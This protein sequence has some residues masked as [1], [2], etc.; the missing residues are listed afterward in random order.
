MKTYNTAGT[1]TA[2]GVTKVRFANDYVG[3]FKILVKNG[4]ENI[5]LIELGEDLTKAEVCKVLLAHP[6]FQSE[7]KQS[8]IAEFV[9]RNVKD[10]VP[11]TTAEPTIAD[12]IEA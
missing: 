12:N 10:I 7:E 6:Q 3:R 11:A 9:V 4:H 5:N 1:S 8:A 2:N